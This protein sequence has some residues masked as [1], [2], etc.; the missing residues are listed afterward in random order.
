MVGARLADELSALSP[1]ITDIKYPDKFLGGHK[2]DTYDVIFI[3]VD[4]PYVDSSN[5]CDLSSVKDAIKEW[6]PSLGVDGVVCIKSTMLPGSSESLHSEW[7][8]PL[9]YSPEYYGNTPHSEGVGSRFTILGG[10]PKSC[11][12]LQQVLQRCHDGTHSFHF[13][14][15]RTAELVKYMENAWLAYKVSFCS[16]FLKIA[17]GCGVRYEDLRELFILDPRVNPSHTFMFRD[18]PYWQSHCL[19]KDV[20]AIAEHS[21]AE[22]LLSMIAFNDKM[23]GEVMSTPS[24][25]L[26]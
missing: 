5:P 24:A 26:P 10:D 1:D 8:A 7:H 9:V 13:T 18:A 25:Y 21:G 22:L 4:T 6:L 23:K 2:Y 12:R 19:D 3:C 15:W 20:R 16:Q 11:Q 14:D 17:D